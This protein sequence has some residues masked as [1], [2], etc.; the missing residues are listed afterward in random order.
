MDPERLE[1][2]N[3]MSHA[4]TVIPFNVIK[5]A[6]IQGVNGAGK[7]VIPDAILLACFGE[8]SRGK[9]SDMIRLG[10]TEMTII[11]DL[12]Q[13]GHLYRILRKW[14]SAGRG[15]TAVELSMHNGGTPPF[16]WEP[17]ATGEEAKKKILELIKRDYES[18]TSS[19]FLLQGQG[20]KLINSKATERYKVV[21]DILGLN[22]YEDLRAK[23]VKKK[24]TCI[25][26]KD[27]LLT[28]IDELRVKAGKLDETAANKER[29]EEEL[30]EIRRGLSEKETV[31]SGK[32]SEV[33]VLRS[34]LK[35]MDSIKVEMTRL[36]SERSGLN[37]QL[38]SLTRSLKLV[39]SDIEEIVLRLVGEMTAEDAI[40][41]SAVISA[42]MDRL[43]K[44]DA[45]ISSLA[46][47]RVTLTSRRREVENLMSAQKKILDNKERI[48]RLVSEETVKTEE[49]TALKSGQESLEREI[50]TITSNLRRG[51][52]L[53]T[54]IAKIE[55]VIA[56]KEKERESALKTAKSDLE[57][58]RTEAELLPRTVCKGEGEYAS[59]PLIK[60]AV[61]SKRLI[62]YHEA[63][64]E[65]F[66]RPLETE[67]KGTLD[68]LLKEWQ[69][70]DTKSLEKALADG[71]SR[72][73]RMKDSIKTLESR[74]ATIRIWT[75]K[76]SRVVPIQPVQ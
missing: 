33:A 26:Q 61:E 45:E 19:S 7:S 28:V 36:E 10:E 76:A 56:I 4:H 23:A 16:D 2:I 68:R 37:A 11:Y 58:A 71:K 59:C 9:G 49:M 67:E 65:A 13:S 34:R 42:E 62:P 40:S 54:E 63:K 44:L 25:G 75:E 53:G 18:M 73:A 51:S 60:K 52:E 20:E 70:L 6:C 5:A 50:E 39:P 74:L 27:T 22:K 64:V 43:K 12:K 3:V 29:I 38:E 69:A 15:K 66:S 32:S 47:R 30:A 57:S 1:L 41:K 31:L 72:I 24:N 21:F 8:C 55:G 14:S 17:I 46:S 35:D 48:L